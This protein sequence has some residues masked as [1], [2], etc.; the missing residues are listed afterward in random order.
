V[1]LQ[2]VPRQLVATLAVG[3]DD[4]DNAA[5]YELEA[6]VRGLGLRAHRPPAMLVHP[7][8]P[9]GPVPDEVVVPVTAR[10]ASRG[11][12]EVREL[13]ACRVAAA[14]HRGFYAGLPDVQ[15][16][17]ERWVA[18]AGLTVTGRLR[19]LYLQFGAEPELRVPPAYVVEREADF[20]TELQ[21]EL[22]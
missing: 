21:L 4:D 8:G 11:G 15:A 3:P 22:A 19:I 16:A 12:I 14:V 1:V 7:Q 13:P 18:A 6:V 9:D 10:F 20:V 17:L 2:P 5:F